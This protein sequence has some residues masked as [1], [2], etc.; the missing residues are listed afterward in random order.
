MKYTVPKLGARTN[1]GWLQTG[2]A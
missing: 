1:E 2:G